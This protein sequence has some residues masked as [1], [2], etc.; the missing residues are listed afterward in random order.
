MIVQEKERGI[1]LTCLGI[2][3]GNYKDSKIQTLAQRGNGNFAYLDSYAEAEKVLLKEF[4][5]TLY[6]VADDAYLNVQFDPELVKEYRLLGF[7]NKMGAIKDTTATIEGGE[8]GSAY[9]LLIAFEIVPVRPI[10]PDAVNFVKPA[11]FAL[12]YREAGSNTYQVL[13]ETPEIPFQSFQQTERFYQF[14]T[15]VLMFGQTL[16]KSRYFKEANWNQIL[17]M[18]SVSADMN[19]FSQK[20]FLLMVQQAKLLYSKKRKKEKDED[21]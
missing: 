9:S 5:Q 19:N 7:D 3:M 14:A 13:N 2:G 1:Y 16:R 11:S 6:T 15:A 20:E 10:N 18:A 4:A 21:Q 8:I 12:Q 17:Q